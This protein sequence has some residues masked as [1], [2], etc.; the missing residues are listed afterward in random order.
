MSGLV[1][2]ITAGDLKTFK[3]NTFNC[4]F[5]FEKMKTRKGK[6]K[7]FF[8]VQVPFSEND[9]VETEPASKQKRIYSRCEQLFLVCQA[10]HEVM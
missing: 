2:D 9:F 3:S 7:S 4:Q 5:L 1:Y 6:Y 8:M 10:A